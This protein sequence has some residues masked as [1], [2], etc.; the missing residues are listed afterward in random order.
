MESIFLT[1]SFLSTEFLLF[2]AAIINHFY[3]FSCG[4]STITRLF[5]ISH[6]I[7]ILLNLSFDPS[8]LNTLLSYSLT[9]AYYFYRLPLSWLY[10]KPFNFCPICISDSVPMWP[11]TMCVSNSPLFWTD[12]CPG[13]NHKYLASNCKAT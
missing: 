13:T 11:Y 5:H 4:F 2:N 9:T 12:L 10:M 1:F 6:F 8:V 7:S 3:R